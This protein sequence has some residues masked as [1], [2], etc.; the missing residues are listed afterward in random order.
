MTS[1]KLQCSLS[2]KMYLFCHLAGIFSTVFCSKPLG[3]LIIRLINFFIC[4]TYYTNRRIKIKDLCIDYR[5]VLQ[6]GRHFFK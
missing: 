4:V 3:Y 2:I 1:I 6:I 5:V